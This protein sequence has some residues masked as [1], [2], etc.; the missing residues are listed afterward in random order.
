MKTQKI[1]INNA[2][3]ALR[4]IV[5][6]KDK[7]LRPYLY[8]VHV[9][10][11]AGKPVAIATNGHQL[12]KVRIDGENGE[13]IETDFAFSSE[14]LEKYRKKAGRKTQPIPP[15]LTVDE[16]GVATV[17]HEG[18][19][20]SSQVI[21]GKLLDDSPLWPSPE[22]DYQPVAFCADLLT[23]LLK[24]TKETE[25]KTLTMWIPVNKDRTPNCKAIPAS[26]GINSDGVKI[27]GLIMPARVNGDGFPKGTN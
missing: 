17:E 23:D 27:D 1:V 4:H 13:E 21:K 15:I 10:K 22:N 3:L 20:L 9:K 18:D 6:D 19:K 5:E 25:A 8:N 11:S 26:L 14:I 2:L 24:F 12:W 7:E 16:K